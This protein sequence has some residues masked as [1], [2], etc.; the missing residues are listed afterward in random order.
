MSMSMCSWKK[1]ECKCYMRLHTKP[2]STGA[3][4]WGS[5]VYWFNS[6]NIMSCFLLENYTRPN[7]FWE[8]ISVHIPIV[9]KAFTLLHLLLGIQIDQWVIN[10]HS[11]ASLLLHKCILGHAV[12][13]KF[14]RPN[15]SNSKSA[16]WWSLIRR[17]A[18]I[19]RDSH[20]PW[21][22]PVWCLYYL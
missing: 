1:Y 15:G 6:Q 13:T 17:P 3:K 2:C 22:K 5:L 18:V 9:A 19:G 14:L 12:H 4:L 11:F 20:I 8:I 16:F 21:V 10:F 7:Q